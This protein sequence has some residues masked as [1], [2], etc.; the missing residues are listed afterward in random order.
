M[1]TAKAKILSSMGLLFCIAISLVSIVGYLDF[2]QASVKNYTNAL[3]NQ[4]FLI[5][6]SVEQKMS[7]IFD[8]LHVMSAGLGLDPQQPLDQD[9]LLVSLFAIADNLDVVQSYIAVASGITYSTARRGVVPNFNAK[10]KQREWFIRGFNGEE[11]ILTK[12]YVSSEG[13]AVMAAAVPVKFDGKVVAVL[14]VNL[15]VGQITEFINGL[16]QNNQ[17]FVSNADGYV[18]AAKYPDYVGKDLLKLRPSYRPFSG[19]PKGTHSYF[20]DG[21]EYLVVSTTLPGLGWTTWAWDTW[22]TIE[23][24]SN[25]ALITTALLAFVLFIASLTIIYFLVLKIIYLPI[26]GE[27]SELERMVKKVSDGDL[28][29]TGN[30]SGAETGVYAAILHM[31]SNLRDMVTHINHT[32]EQ[33]SQF[34]GRINESASAVTN[35]SESQMLQLEQTSTAMNEMTMTADEVARNAQQASTAVLEANSH[36]QKGFEVVDEMGSDIRQL[37]SGI[38]DVEKVV[39]ALADETLN[40]GKILDVIRGIADQTNLL[41]LNAAIEAARAGE[42]GRGF[43]VVADEVRSLANRTQESTNEIQDMISKLQTEADKSVQLMQVNTLD[44]KNTAGKSDQANQVLRDIRSSVGVIQ[45]MNNQIATAAEE[46][47]LVA[48]DINASVVGINDLAKSTFDGSKDN[49]QRAQELLQTAIA[50]ND[51]VDSFKL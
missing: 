11:N 45:D 10:D 22:D 38:E 14:S 21:D 4:A 25:D 27:P 24:A 30:A 15:K 40:I 46:Q 19:Q 42:Q 20:F 16:T 47:T 44:A 37:A 8:A 35:S 13:V 28:N 29:C 39:N 3:D 49:T 17:L 2:K 34:S 5:S 51:S 12:P 7:R 6:K 31:V 23:S 9:K 1:M 41:A 43:A 32:S 48:A 33:L 36:S 50:L 18:L 26:G